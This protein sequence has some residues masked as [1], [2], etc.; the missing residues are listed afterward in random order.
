VAGA[1]VFRRKYR[2]AREKWPVPGRFRCPS[3]DA[4]GALARKWTVPVPGKVQ[5]FTAD[6]VKRLHDS[7]IPGRRGLDTAI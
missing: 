7:Q 5:P 4:S 6:S 3:E 1:L 2:A